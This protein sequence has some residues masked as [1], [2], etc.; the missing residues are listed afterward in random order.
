MDSSV[1][2]CETATNVG[3]LRG[4]WLWHLKKRPKEIGSEASATMHLVRSTKIETKPSGS[5]ITS[6]SS[7]WH[8]A[9]TLY[10]KQLPDEDQ[11]SIISTMDDSALTAQSVEALI[12]PLIAKH[13]HGA[14]TKLLLK[15]GPTLQHIRSFATIVDVAVQSHPNVA[16]LIW[17]GVRLILEVWLT[18]E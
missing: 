6:T 3:G 2:K 5:S 18:A 12:S 1:T 10:I 13:K 15:L 17:G 4:R 16:C 14:I 11:Q 8:D 9:I 7:I